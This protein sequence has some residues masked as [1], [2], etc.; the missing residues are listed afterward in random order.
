MTPLLEKLKKNAMLKNKLT[1]A[2]ECPILNSTE[3]I[4]TKIPAINIALSGDAFGG[5]RP[6]LLLLAAPSAHYKT[7]LGLLIVAAYLQTYKEAICFFFDS[8][9]GVT[10]DYLK[11]QGVDTSRMVHIPVTNIEELKFQTKAILDNIELGDKAILFIDSIG[12][13]ASKKEEDDAAD[14]KSVADMSRAKA[15]KQYFRIVT[16]HLASKQICMVAVNHT[17]QEIGMFPKTIMGGGTGARYSGNHIIYVSKSQ[18]K[19]GTDLL[20]FVFKLIIEKSRFVR[21][22]SIIPIVVEFEKGIRK[23]SGMFDIACELGWITSPSKGWYSVV[24]KQTG[25]IEDKKYRRADIEHNDEFWK[26][27]FD[28]GLNEDI[29]LRYQYQDDEVIEDNISD[30]DNDEE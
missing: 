25:E 3:F 27:M 5:L 12:N 23:W 1:F 9:F 7:L 22:K 11:S 8:E 4:T 6:G 17:Y 13:L 20:G 2:N 30:L 15:L 10:L 29:K 28:K 24:D 18:E 21:E 19:D 26:T 14:G 16:P